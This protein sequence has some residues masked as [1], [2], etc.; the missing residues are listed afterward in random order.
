MALHKVKQGLSLPIK[1]APEPQVED[2]RRP[3]RVALVAADYVGMKP[4]MHVKVGDGVRRGQLLFEDKKRPGVRYTALGSGKVVAVNRGARRALQTVVI[5]L[6]PGET[7][8]T[9]RFAADT[10]KHPSGLSREQVRDLLLESGLWTAL[11]TRPFG[12][13]A[14]P[15][16]APLA[17]FV[18]AMDTSPLAPPTD[19]ILAG[20]EDHVERGLAAVAKLTDGVTYVCTG[21]DT[22]LSLPAEGRF[23]HE[24]FTGPHPAGTVG[25]HIHAL[26]PVT[27]EKFVWH[28]GL[29]DLIA[30]GKLFHN[31]V[32][33]P[34]RIISLGGPMVRRPRLL[35]TRLGAF[36]GDLTAGE[37]EPEEVRVISGSVF[38][39]RMAQGEVHG[40]LGRYHQQVSVIAE[41]RDREFLGWLTPGFDRYSTINTFLSRLM[42]GKKFAFTTTT[43]GSDRAIVPIGMY[44]RVF[45]FDIL[46]TAMLRAV[47]MQDVEQAERLGVLELEEEDLG[48]CSFVCPGKHNYGTELRRLLTTIEKEG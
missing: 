17:V 22:K 3:A 4:T 5:E 23:Q 41:G 9:V 2:A 21:P 39:G 16:S 44:E 34:S 32:L 43:H 29:Q 27:R 6:D 45:P 47:V 37:L 25:Y 24:T 1:G 8:D 14:D 36:L 35:R 38:S 26:R 28:I 46:A 48:L 31:G 40:Y 42:P 11:R 20:Q 10:G 18:T 13:V 15:Q 19:V 7:A 30:I 33:D 12:H